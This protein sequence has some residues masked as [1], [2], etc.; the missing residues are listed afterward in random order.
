AL[1]GYTAQSNLVSYNT[2]P[3]L[4][5]NSGSAAS[6]VFSSWV[7]GEY[8]HLSKVSWFSSTCT[9]PNTPVFFWFTLQEL[10][11]SLTKLQVNY[12]NERPGILQIPLD[13]QNK[14]ANPRKYVTLKLHL[15][16]DYL[17]YLRTSCIPGYSDAGAYIH[18]NLLVPKMGN[19]AAVATAFS[20]GLP[21]GISGTNKKCTVLVSNLNEDRIDEDKLFNLFSIYGNIVRVKLLRNKPDHALVQ[22]GDGFRG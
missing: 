7:C 14:K 18:F 12:N 22:M 19:A 3:A 8:R 1:S 11:F 15:A 13:R 10:L 5:Y 4:F 20:G 16:F 17:P 9:I 21:P 2:S 6:I